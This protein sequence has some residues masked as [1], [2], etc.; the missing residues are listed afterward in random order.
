MSFLLDIRRP[1]PDP[2]WL[3]HSPLIF[4]IVISAGLVGFLSEF[5]QG[6]LPYRLFDWGD[7]AANLSLLP[8]TIGLS[9]YTW[10]STRR[11]GE[12]E[13]QGE[14]AEQEELLRNLGREP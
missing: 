9:W 14:R 5:I 2:R 13:E 7:V 1:D 4:T 10:H 3:P 11:D 8:F 6:L 12:G